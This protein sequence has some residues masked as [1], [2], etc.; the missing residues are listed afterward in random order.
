M[1]GIGAYLAGNILNASLKAVASM[2]SPATLG[3]GLCAGAPTSV[4]QSEIGAASGY[5]PQTLSMSSV[6]TGGSIMVASN[7]STCSYGTFN[8]S[9]PI[10]GVVVKD[11]LATAAGNIYYFG[12]L[13][14]ARTVLSG[15]SIIVAVGALT[16]TLS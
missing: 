8:A 16:I 4:S 5:T 3:L 14:T 6:S 12:T 9:G 11:T 1:A 10:S 15:D 13:A 7:M 2:V